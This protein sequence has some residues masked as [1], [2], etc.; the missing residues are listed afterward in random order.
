MQLIQLQPGEKQFCSL[1]NK[2]RLKLSKDKNKFQKSNLR[3]NISP[4]IEILLTR[5]DVE[6]DIKILSSGISVPF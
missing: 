2:I 1:K 3:K 6:K 4:D 5:L